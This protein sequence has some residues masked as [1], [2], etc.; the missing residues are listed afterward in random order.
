ME[1]SQR[2]SNIYASRL[3][4]KEKVSSLSYKNGFQPEHYE[5]Y[6]RNNNNLRPRK[7]IV[8]LYAGNDLGS[9]L[10]ETLYDYSSNKLELPYRKIFLRGQIGNAPS[11]YIFPLNKLADQS[12]FVEL[13]LKVIGKTPFR[14][15]L[16]RQ[17]FE[18]PNSPNSIELERGHTNLIDNRAVKSLVRLR[19]LVEERGGRLLIVLIPQNFYFGDDNPHINSK[20]KNQ[21]TDIRSGNNL[22]NNL[23][24]VCGNLRLECLDARPFLSRDSY[25]SADAHWNS[26]GHANIGIALS[27]YLK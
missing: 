24:M 18:G 26:K 14:P 19:G 11:V 1:V 23:V 8:G 9:D 13:F 15:Y 12:S 20:L 3:S 22:L 7:V 17:G 2:Y 6:F 27:N 10:E 4:S 16:F 5:Y 21:L 25:F